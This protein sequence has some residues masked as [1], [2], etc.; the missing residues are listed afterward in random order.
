M[1]LGLSLNQELASV[2]KLAA[3]YRDR[4]MDLADACVVRMSEMFPLCKVFTVCRAD[5]STYRRFGNKPV[6]CRFSDLAL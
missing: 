1:T 3:K 2:K 5:F 4:P 6:P